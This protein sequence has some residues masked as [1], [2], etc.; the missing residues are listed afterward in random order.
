M[1][2]FK[3][4]HES[5]KAGDITRLEA[6]MQFHQIH[7]RLFQ[8]RE[9]LQR[10]G[11][12]R[13]QILQ[14]HVILTTARGA[15]FIVDEQDVRSNPIEYLNF[16]TLEGVDE[17]VFLELCNR[18]EVIVDIG[19]N[20][21]WYSI[22]AARLNPNLKN[23]YAFE[24]L[25][26]NLALLK[27]NIDLNK[28]YSD[29]II[30]HSCALGDRNGYRD[31][32]SS[33]EEKGASSFFNIR[34]LQ[35]PLVSNVEVRR[36][37]EVSLDWGELGEKSLLKI[38]TEGS[39]YLVLL[40]AMSFLAENRPVVFCEILRKW[41]AK[42]GVDYNASVKL[43]TDIGYEVFTTIAGSDGLHTFSVIDETTE[44]TNFFFFPR[45]KI[46]N[47]IRSGACKIY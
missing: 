24:P 33:E 47:Y 15:I 1:T 11:G 13:I 23:I 44:A 12:G 14:D 19:A 30:V 34:D 45:E 8:Y 31:L 18:S 35:E 32:L 9:L 4:I 43:L 28:P 25:P 22:H 26:Q 7:Q 21:G 6:A 42:A 17:R 41:S 27:N 38:D 39:E 46:S 20:I 3:D 29:R 16:G 37:D 2:K 5:Y 36:L 40:G 10:A